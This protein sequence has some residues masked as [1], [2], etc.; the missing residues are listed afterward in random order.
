MRLGHHAVAATVALGLPLALA[1]MGHPGI[2]PEQALAAAVLAQPF[3]A[4]RFSPDA[5]QTWLKAA[6]HRRGV[7]G[8]W[9]PALAGLALVLSGF[10]TVY[11]LWGPIIGWGSHLFPADWFFGKG[12]RSIPKGIPL[13]PFCKR[14]TGVGWRVS[15]R[16]KPW[17]RFFKPKRG[18]HALGELLTSWVVVLAVVP[19]LTWLTL[20]AM[21]PVA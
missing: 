6:G 3:S 18:G 11:A 2:A 9:W 7:H 8:W 14:R 20:A 10:G 13:L 17:D 5:D 19:Y 15:R 21:T 1:R 12:G 4:G 16:P